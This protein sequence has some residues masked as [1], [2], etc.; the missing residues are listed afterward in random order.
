MNNITPRQI[1]WGIVNS[2]FLICLYLGLIEHIEGAKNIALALA[3]FT[4]ISTPIFFTDMY[5]KTMTESGYTV[6]ALV[7]GII[8]FTALFIMVWTGY[9]VLGGFYTIHILVSQGA[10]AATLKKIAK[11]AT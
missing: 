6:P 4:V 5:T 10:R 11:K 7:E 3:W 8:D 1:R 2:I 9:L